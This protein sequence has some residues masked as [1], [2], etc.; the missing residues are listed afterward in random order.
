MKGLVWTSLCT[1]LVLSACGNKA[2]FTIHNETG[3]RL[4]LV[5]RA[6][7]AGQGEAW[8]LARGESRTLTLDPVSPGANVSRTVSGSGDWKMPFTNLYRLT[9]VDGWAASGDT[10][11][12]GP[13]F[14]QIQFT[15]QPEFTNQTLAWV[16]VSTN[17]NGALLSVLSPGNPFTTNFR[18]TNDEPVRFRAALVS[19]GGRVRI[20]VA[21]N[22]TNFT[23]PYQAGLCVVRWNGWTF[24]AE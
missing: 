17:T 22:G 1:A 7:D 9:P 2:L 19:N 12:I 11:T 15:A 6:P 4:D 13:D 21:V 18:L 23:A 5:V 3:G 16:D 14:Y 10:L 8:T 24:T 20:Q